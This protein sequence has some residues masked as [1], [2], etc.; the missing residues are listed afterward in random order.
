MLDINQSLETIK[1]MKKGSFM[2]M[3][4]ERIKNK[5]FQSLEK[6]KKSH[7]KVQEIEHNSIT[8]QKYLQPNKTNIT[9]EEAKLIFKLR[10]QVTDTKVN[11]KGIY[12]DLACTAC[13]KGE[14]NPKHIIMCEELNTEKNIHEIKYEY[15][16][17]GTV[18]EKL[19]IARIFKVN[20]NILE[21]LKKE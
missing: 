4:K 1:S 18:N 9:R 3:V 19:E 21:K 17:N 20:Y 15:I 7:S 14:E 11:L 6:I 5:S 16:L 2:N 8:M 13:G 12:D 10:C